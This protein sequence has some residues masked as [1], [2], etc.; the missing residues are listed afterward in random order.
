MVLHYILILVLSLC[1]IVGWGLLFYTVITTQKC[2]REE[3]NLI[4][5]IHRDL[6]L[7]KQELEELK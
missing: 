4:T 5:D 2:R 1:S 3:L 7:V 6:E